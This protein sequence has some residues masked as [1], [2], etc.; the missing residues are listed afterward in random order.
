MDKKYNHI[1]NLSWQSTC[2]SVDQQQKTKMRD[3][4]NTYINLA[5]SCG[6]RQLFLVSDTKRMIN[7]LQGRPKLLKLFQMLLH[8]ERTISV[9]T[10]FRC[11]ITELLQRSCPQKSHE[12]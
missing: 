5:T 6:A 7:I 4:I 1:A 11:N 2:I 10:L 3:Q 8:L 12:N 9:D